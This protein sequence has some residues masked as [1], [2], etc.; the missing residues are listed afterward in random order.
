MSIRCWARAGWSCGGGILRSF[1]GW[2]LRSVA[3]SALRGSLPSPLVG[4]VRAAVLA[5][6]RLLAV[7]QGAVVA[8]V[9]GGHGGP[10]GAAASGHEVARG[11]GEAAHSTALAWANARIPTPVRTDVVDESVRDTH[12]RASSSFGSVHAVRS[13]APTHTGMSV[14]SL[15]ASTSA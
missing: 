15:D 2:E 1:G 6:E 14:C 11:D 9:P 10:A 3:R 12:T 4:A 5:P 7:H 8:G 13:T